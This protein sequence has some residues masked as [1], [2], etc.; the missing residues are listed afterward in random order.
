MN[1]RVNKK[2]EIQNLSYCFSAGSTPHAI[3]KSVCSLFS[4]TGFY[5]FLV[6]FKILYLAILGYKGLEVHPD[7]L[8]PHYQNP[9][10]LL[11]MYWK[12]LTLL[13]YIN[14]KRGE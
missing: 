4:S 14:M 12:V 5:W 6:G 11:T 10:G 9:S 2:G 13:I 8:L 7:L 3:S 1:R